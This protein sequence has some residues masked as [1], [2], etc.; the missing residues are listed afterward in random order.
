[1]CVVGVW[2]QMARTH[3]TAL[4]PAVTWGIVAL[5]PAV[6]LAGQDTRAILG[7]LVNLDERGEILVVM[8][9][10][11]VLARVSDLERAGLRGFA[12][13]RDTLA[14]EPYVS[15]SSLAPAITYV[16]DEHALTLRLTVPP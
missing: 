15:L 11:D 14:G 5:C 10:G 13:Q 8:Q 16:L 1:M 7:L 3:C 6:C 2:L 4:V 12:G 9:E